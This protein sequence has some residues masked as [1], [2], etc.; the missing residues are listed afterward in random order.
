[1]IFIL[2][3]QYKNRMLTDKEAEFQ[4]LKSERCA[5]CKKLCSTRSTRNTIALWI[6]VV[7]GTIFI[8][9]VITIACLYKRTY[10]GPYH[11]DNGVTDCRTCTTWTSCPSTCQVLNCQQCLDITGQ[12]WTCTDAYQNE[13]SNMLTDLLPA[14]VVMIIVT[15][16]FGISYIY[17][18]IT[19][20][21]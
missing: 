4:R 19:E 7:A 9:C 17:F 13:T 11:C 20:D 18:R 10:Y 6:N 1:M 16:I 5:C 14:F 12:S 21:I 15:C 8:A 2:K 3:F